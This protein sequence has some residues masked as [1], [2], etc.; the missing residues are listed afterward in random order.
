M[1]ERTSSKL[2]VIFC[3]SSLHVICMCNT[4][5]YESHLSEQLNVI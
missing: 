4:C 2:K 3:Y 1:F 5:N